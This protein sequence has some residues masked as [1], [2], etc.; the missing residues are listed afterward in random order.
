MP[1]FRMF[2]G[3]VRSALVHAVTQYDVRQARGKRYNRYAVGQYLRRVDDICDDIA[4][5]AQPRAA[6]V[7]GMTGSLLACCLKA[8]GEAAPTR[9]EL[10]GTG[11]YTY[12]PASA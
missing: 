4:K 2:G 6:I 8:V 7:A 10:N 5:G 1:E 12:Q 3:T 11:K 9:D